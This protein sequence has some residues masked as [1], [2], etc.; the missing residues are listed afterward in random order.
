[1]RTSAPLLLPIFRSELQG[2]LLALLYA[3]SDRGQSITALAARLGSHVAT[4]QR[5]V[6]RLEESGILTSER[7]GHTRLVRPD[8][9]SP[10]AED[11]S[12]LVIKAFGPAHVLGPLLAGIPGVEHAYLFGSWASRYRGASGPAPADIDVLVIGKPDRDAVDRVALE[13]QQQV[14]RE[15]NI[16]IRSRE[17]WERGDDGFLQSVRAGDLVP[18]ELDDDR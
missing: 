3:R 14:G 1:M 2:R 18:I 16:T 17:A 6:A 12:S 13:V 5:E 8:L 4:V 7:V 15:V 10:Y 11:L 9:S